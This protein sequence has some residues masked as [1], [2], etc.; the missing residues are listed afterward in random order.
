MNVGTGPRGSGVTHRA[1]AAW[2]QGG[3]QPANCMSHPSAK[4]A[5]NPAPDPVIPRVFL[6][7]DPA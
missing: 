4:Q 5:P 2:P 6:S 7:A 1:T 3:A